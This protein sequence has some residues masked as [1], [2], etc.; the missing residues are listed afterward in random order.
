MTDLPHSR[1]QWDNLPEFSLLLL[2]WDFDDPWLVNDACCSVALLNDPDDPGLV[3]LLFL[4]VFTEGGSLF[5]WQCNQ[6]ST[7]DQSGGLM[8]DYFAILICQLIVH[9]M[10]ANLE[11]YF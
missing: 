9:S 11:Y 6:K 8:D 2:G 7:Y 5:S 1:S 3:T 4:D 10:C